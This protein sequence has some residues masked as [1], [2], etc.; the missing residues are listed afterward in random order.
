MNFVDFQSSLQ[1]S[2]SSLPFVI[3][4]EPHHIGSGNAPN[5]VA[6]LHYPCLSA[7][8]CRSIPQRVISGTSLA[9]V[10]TTGATAGAV[11][12]SS[13]CVEVRTAALLAAAAVVTAPF[14]A[15]LTHKVDCQVGDRRL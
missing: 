11:Y 14:G 2:L 1:F 9:A 4:L 3:G 15:K 7:C 10:A 13:D 12:W 6:T 5:Q 8:R